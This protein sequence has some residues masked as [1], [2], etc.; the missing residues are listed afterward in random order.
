MKKGTVTA[1]GAQNFSLYKANVKDLVLGEYAPSREAGHALIEE[2]AGAEYGLSGDWNHISLTILRTE[3][4][5]VTFIEPSQ[6][7]GFGLAVRSALRITETPY[8][9]VHQHDWALIYDIPLEPMLDVMR[10][11]EPDETAPVKYICLPSAR[12]VAYAVSAHVT[13]F[14][15]LRALTATLKR[16]FTSELFPGLEIPLTP[17]FFW[18][19]KPHIASTAHYLA[20][21]FPSRL[22]LPRGS[23]IEDTVGHRAREQMKTGVWAK[24]ACWLYYPNQG[25]QLCV[26]HLHGRTWRGAEFELQMKLQWARESGDSQGGETQGDDG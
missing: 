20:R 24:W 3:D 23:F 15:K 2:V 21:V 7:L 1:E 22:A 5:Q 10:S 8:V 25:K 14:P 26:R 17:L 11:S 9:W 19:D 4:K 12:M 18:H 13:C 6:R 16:D